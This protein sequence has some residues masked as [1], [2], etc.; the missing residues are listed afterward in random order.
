MLR[1]RGAD[2]LGG[3]A[4]ADR[5]A[6][7]RGEPGYA[8]VPTARG[9]RAAADATAL[10]RAEPA[11]TDARRDGLGELKRHRERLARARGR[12]LGCA[13]ACDAAS[14]SWIVRGAGRG[15]A[16]SASWIVRERVAATPR[17]Q[18]IVERPCD[19]PASRI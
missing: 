11:P 18:W 6:V 12:H 14:A 4:S 2:G 17:A 8:A 16:A 13:A 9:P 7:L 15:N 3:R 1:P 19:G 10:E 5:A